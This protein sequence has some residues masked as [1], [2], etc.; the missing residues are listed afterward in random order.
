VTFM[1]TRRVTGTLQNSGSGGEED[2]G[3]RQPDAR[4]A[5]VTHTE[6]R[7]TLEP[8]A[9]AGV[10]PIATNTP[11]YIAYGVSSTTTKWSR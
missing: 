3:H 7:D 4:D 9:R 8:K 6:D 10:I 5:P 2:A 1:R 11:G